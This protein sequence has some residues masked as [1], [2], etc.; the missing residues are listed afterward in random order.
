MK[1]ISKNKLKFIA[2]GILIVLVIIISGIWLLALNSKNQMIE[3]MLKAP[4][5]NA[6]A[7]FSFDENGEVIEDGSSIFFIADPPLVMA[8]TVKLVILGA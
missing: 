5:A 4:T 8:S 6:I 1:R 3:A 7:A 2:W